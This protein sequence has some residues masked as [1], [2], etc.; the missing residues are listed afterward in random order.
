L[1]DKKRIHF[2]SGLSNTAGKK[3]LETG[4]QGDQIGRIFAYCVTVCFGQ[5][6]ENK[7]NSRHFWNT[8]FTVKMYSNFGEKMG[9][10]SFWAIFSQTHLVTLPGMT[11]LGEVS[12][13]G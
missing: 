10:A 12:P 1:I 8:F 2:F 4:N 11:R 6:F 13:I 7:R 9:W 5:F 3:Y